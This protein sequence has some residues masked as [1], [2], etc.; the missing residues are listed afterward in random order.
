MGGA[1]LKKTSA[2]LKLGS[3]AHGIKACAGLREEERR[4]KKEK[5][6]AL[7]GLIG[8]AHGAKRAR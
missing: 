8:A 7:R 6:R 3:S 2:R 5:S 1:Q 4:W